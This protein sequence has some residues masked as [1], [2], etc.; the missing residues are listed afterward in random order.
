[1]RLKI[2]DS[3]LTCKVADKCLNVC[4][5]AEVAEWNK[6]WSP[7]FPCCPVNRQSLWKKT[8]I[9]KVTVVHFSVSN[10]IW[11]CLHLK[12]LYLVLNLFQIFWLSK[13]WSELNEKFL[14]GLVITFVK[15][16]NARMCS[17]KT[18]QLYPK[19]ISLWVHSSKFC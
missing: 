12:R 9:E 19:R 14:Y 15:K 3:H 18:P 2:R 17:A 1:M 5:R 4:E 16:A 7:P 13:Y 8:L 10:I 6:R 11:F